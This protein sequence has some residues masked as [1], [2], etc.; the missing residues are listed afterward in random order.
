MAPPAS[1]GSGS[2]AGHPAPPSP[3]IEVIYIPEALERCWQFLP[4]ITKSQT[5]PSKQYSLPTQYTK[6]PGYNTT[7]RAVGANLNAYKVLQFPNIKI[8]QYDVVIGSG[9]EKRTVNNKV[10][11][12]QARKNATGP[13][14][15]WDGNRLAWSLRD[16]NEIRLMVDLDQEEGRPPRADGRNS[17][18]VAI[19]KTRELDVSLIQQY[20]EGRVQMNQY[21]AEGLM[22]LDHLLRESPRSSPQFIPIRRNL[23]RRQGQRADLGGGIEV[24][25]GVYQSMRLAEGQK[26][27][28]NVD[29]ANTCFWRPTSLTSA[30]VTKWREIKDLNDIANRMEPYRDNGHRSITEFHVTLQ[31]AFKGVEV[32]ASYKGNPNPDKVWKIYRF[33]INNA[34]EEMIEWKDPVTRQSTGEM[35]S[36]AHYFKRKYNLTLQYPKLRLVEMTRQGVKYPMELLSI[37][38]GQRYGAK[39]DEIQTANMIKFAVSPPNVRLNA[40]NEGKS[41]LNWEG[42]N[43]LKNYRLHINPAPIK[44]MAR[45][46]PAPGIKF[47]NKVEQVGTRGRWDLKAKT[48]LSRNPQELVSWGV[49]VFPGR[50]KVEKAQI[51]QFVLDFARAYRNHG[52]QVAN[53]PPYVTTLSAD[54]GAAVAALHQ[55]TGNKFNR[56]P[57]LLIFLVQDRQSFHYLRIKKSCDC[58]FGVVS[59][60]MQIQQVLK[61]NPQYYSNVLM[62][63]NAK[64]GGT[65][66]QAIPHP[67]S[68]FKSFQVPTMIIGAD[69]SHASPG[70]QQPSMAAVTVSFDRFGGRYAAACQ[71]NGRR[72]EMIS[73]ANWRNILRP[74][75]REWMSQVGGGRSPQQVYYMRDGVSTNQFEHVLQQE[76]PHIRSVIESCMDGQKFQGKITVISANKRHHVRCFPDKDGADNKGNPLP[77]MLIERDVTQ[78]NEFDFYL[79]SHIALQGTSRPVHYSVLLDEANHRPELI[80]N[81]IYEHCYQYMRSTTSVSLHPAVYYAHLASNRAKAH[82]D[83]PATHGPQGGAGFKQQNPSRSSEPSDTEVKPLMPLFNVNGIVFAMWYI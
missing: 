71:T 10:W 81:M 40:I 69:V 27:I 36:V 80:Q 28:V 74:L 58:R 72:V 55:A 39:L 65:T 64:L 54:A 50:F 35:V 68:G 56:R 62:K 52:G 1:R 15:I 3:V 24:W 48:F 21:V 41:W 79:Y 33:D 76:V 6:R 20:I 12:S 73:E 78:L 9:G 17:F 29:V 14:I 42:D 53:A 25:R 8:F 37:M 11:D 19:K 82:E 45:I 2:G 57:Q 49:G 46:L 70:S 16:H 51:D 13:P 60:V 18:R 47:G 38:E 43:Y 26:M 5:N 77:G 63:V 67:T 7:G 44:T 83:L 66:A 59:Q 22:F 75:V 30:I 61:G 23:F 32:K 31:K 34:N 4:M